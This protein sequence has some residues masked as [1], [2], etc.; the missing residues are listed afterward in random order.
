MSLDRHVVREEMVLFSEFS[1]R[2]LP[3][4]E[5]DITMPMAQ[6][7]KSR[8]FELLDGKID[9][10]YHFETD[11]FFVY[12]MGGEFCD[13]TGYNGADVVVEKWHPHPVEPRGNERDFS[14]A[15]YPDKV[16]NRPNN[17]MLWRVFYDD[18]TSE[19]EEATESQSSSECYEPTAQELQVIFDLLNQC[20]E[21]NYILGTPQRIL[22]LRN[23]E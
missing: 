19:I 12:I 15:F 6:K 1:Y 4:S 10:H 23:P 16:F 2:K 11:R 5:H 21:S 13:S 17:S 7:V 9:A 3:Q 20:N 22:E 14:Y 8:A 18:G